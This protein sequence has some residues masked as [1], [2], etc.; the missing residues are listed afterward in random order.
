VVQGWQRR[1]NK[2]KNALFVTTEIKKY[3]RNRNKGVHNFAS[4][5]GPEDGSQRKRSLNL[6]LEDEE[7]SKKRRKSFQ[8][9]RRESCYLV[10][11]TVMYTYFILLLCW[12]GVHC[13]I[14]KGSYN[15]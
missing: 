12:V 15:I 13:G 10:L 8:K 7:H 4:G 2:N 6:A 9:A 1:C 5:K 3:H 14:Y 11:H